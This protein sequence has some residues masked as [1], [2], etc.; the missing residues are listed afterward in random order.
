MPIPCVYSI[1]LQIRQ[2]YVLVSGNSCRN[3]GNNR[4]P[5]LP[6]RGL[7][8]VRQLKV[9]NIAELREFPSVD[10]FPNVHT[11][12]LSYA[13]HCCEFLS[14]DESGMENGDQVSETWWH[15]EDGQLDPSLWSLNETDLWPNYREFASDRR[16]RVATRGNSLSMYVCFSMKALIPSK[17]MLPV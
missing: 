2:I 8:N 15:P 1:C 17:S 12:I 9:H 11:L 3:L 14:T 4:F 16:F 13:Y 5:L 7:E 10:H 6:E